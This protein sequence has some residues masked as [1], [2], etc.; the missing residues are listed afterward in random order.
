MSNLDSELEVGHYLSWGSRM[1]RR[2]GVTSCAAITAW[3]IKKIPTRP[4]N[5]TRLT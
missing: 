2:W 3:I 1:G 5:R 4:S